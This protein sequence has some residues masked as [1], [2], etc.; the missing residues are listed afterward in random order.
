MT[1]ERLAEIEAELGQLATIPLVAELVAEVRRLST[2][3]WLSVLAVV[4]R[5]P[6]AVAWLCTANPAFKGWAPAEA[7]TAWPDGVL[8]EVLALAEGVTS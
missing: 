3:D 7:I 6:A 8:A 4:L 1:D 5:S 2:P